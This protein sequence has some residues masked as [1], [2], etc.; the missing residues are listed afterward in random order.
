M[1]TTVIVTWSRRVVCMPR[2]Q[3]LARFITMP[4]GKKAPPQ[5]ASLTELWGSK[6]K[7]ENAPTTTPAAAHAGSRTDDVAAD[8][9]PTTGPTTSSEPAIPKRNQEKVTGGV[10]SDDRS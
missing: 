1:L 10:E 5:Q 3:T 8:A 9:G 7:R 6:R 2:Q 4:P